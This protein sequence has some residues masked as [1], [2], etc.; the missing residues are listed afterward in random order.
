MK[1]KKLV[2]DSFEYFVADVPIAQNYSDVSKMFK[3]MKN[4]KIG[5]DAVIF[6]IGANIGIFSLAYSIIFK[7]STVYSFKPVPFIYE[8]CAKVLI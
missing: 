3:Y 8:N 2:L 7:H 6:D 4:L 1:K 5:N